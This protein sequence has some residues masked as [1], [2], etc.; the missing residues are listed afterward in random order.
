MNLTAI[1]LTSIE[2][3]WRALNS[4]RHLVFDLKEQHMCPPQTFSPPAVAP[5][6]RQVG[7]SGCSISK[8]VKNEGSV[9]SLHPNE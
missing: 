5:S 3:S 1:L 9:F 6:Y 7:S 4:V 8:R 2:E